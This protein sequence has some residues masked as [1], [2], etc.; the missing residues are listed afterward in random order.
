MELGHGTTPFEHFTEPISYKTFEIFMKKNIPCT[1]ASWISSDWNARKYWALDNDQPNFDFLEEKYGNLSASVSKFSNNNEFDCFSQTISQFILYW[2]SLILKRDLS[3]I[4]NVEFFPLTDFHL[5]PHYLK[6]WHFAQAS[7]PSSVYRVP[8]FFTDDWLN[9]FW[10]I[11]NDVDDDY[12]FSYFGPAGSFTPFHADV[13]RSYSWSVNVCGRKKW[14]ILYPG[15]ELKLNRNYLN[16]E[17]Q[18][19][20]KGLNYKIVIQNSGE[21]IFVPSGWWHQVLNIADTISIN[22]NWA[23]FHCVPR[24]WSY[25]TSELQLVEHEIRD[26]RHLMTDGEWDEQCQVVLRANI[27]LSFR[28]FFDFVLFNL[29]IKSEDDYIDLISELVFKHKYDIP[30]YYS[31]DEKRSLYYSCK[32]IVKFLKEILPAIRTIEQAQLL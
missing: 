25:L 27:G 16:I 5:L 9:R 28:E 21:G 13:F 2:K 8:D 17:Q 26:C 19:I 23:N 1:F 11:R 3:N 22:H 12:I 10:K 18:C 30:S 20:E 32:D 7:N 24:I 15:E 29:K 31:G 14:L 6:D 4:D